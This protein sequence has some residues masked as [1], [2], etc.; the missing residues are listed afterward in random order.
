MNLEFL[1]SFYFGKTYLAGNTS[2]IFPRHPDGPMQKSAHGITEALPLATA[3]NFTLSP[4]DPMTR[5][6]ITSDSGPIMM[7]D[8]RNKAQNGWFVLRTLLPAG[9]TGDVVVWHVHP[10][11]VRGWVREPVIGYNQVGYTPGRE[12]IS[13]LELDALFTAPAKARRAAINA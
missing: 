1:P 3:A 11:V 7:F 4:E 5:V 13:V 10:N 9:K 2:G 8:G 6:T 12:K